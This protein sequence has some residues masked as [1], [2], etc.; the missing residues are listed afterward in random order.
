M[1]SRLF[2]I[3]FLFSLLL[4]SFP[5]YAA[6]FE[7][8][9]RDLMAN[10][11]PTRQTLCQFYGG[12][13]LSFEQVSQ[14]SLDEVD[15]LVWHCHSSQLPPE[16]LTPQAVKQ[17]KSFIKR[18]G[19][20]FLVS[21][22]Q[23]YTV[24][25]GLEP[26]M[27]DRMDINIARGRFGVHRRVE[28]PIFAGL[29]PEPENPDTFLLSDGYW[30]KVETSL[31]Q[32]TKPQNSR[33]LGSYFRRTGE[34]IYD[35][36]SLSSLNEWSLGSGKVLGYGHNIML[37]Q[38]WDNGDATN[39]HTFLRN[40][41]SYLSE[42]KT[43]TPVVAV[44]PE[45]PSRLHA[46]NHMTPPELPRQQ[47]HSLQRAL[48]GLPYIG[49]FGWLGAVNYQR[50]RRNPPVDLDYFQD[51]L[52]DETW[53]WGGNL[54]E[55]FPEDHGF[56]GYS[57]TWEKDN[58]IPRAQSYLQKEPFWP[59]WD[60]P[61]MRQVT[62]HAHQRDFL[63]HTF[64]HRRPARGFGET[65][66]FT[67]LVGRE[68]MNP[69]LYSW[70]Q[71]QDGFGVEGWFSDP[72]GE[73]FNRI[74]PYNP[75]SYFHT[76]A[77]LPGRSP[78]LSGSWMCA[79]GRVRGSFTNGFGNRWRYIQHPPLFLSYQADCRSR[80]PSRK[81]SGWSSAYGG[82]STPDWIMRQVNDFCRDRL[83]MDSA[84][85]WLGEPSGTMPAEFRPY[86]YAIS[87]NPMRV[88]LTTTLHDIGEHGY[89][90]QTVGVSKGRIP[91]RWSNKIPFPSN[92]S[93]I[94]NNYFR[95][96]RMVGEDRGVLQYDPHRTAFFHDMER[97]H[98][99]VEVSA[100]LLSCP[101]PI[102]DPL[103]GKTDG[104]VL[105]LGVVDGSSSEFKDLGGYEMTYT[106]GEGASNFP[107]KLGYEIYPAWP[108][109]VH[110]P[111]FLDAGCYSLE[112][113]T[114]PVDA[115]AI[116]HVLLDGEK[117]GY[118]F[119]T[120]GKT[121]YSVPFSIAQPGAHSLS[122]WVERAHEFPRRSKPS[123]Q[124]RIQRETPHTFDALRVRIIS[125]ISITHKRL[126]AVGHT[127]LL[128][129][130]VCF[131]SEAKVK[132]VRRYSVNSD[133]PVLRIE[134]E[135]SAPTAA[136]WQARL[137]LANYGELQP[138]PGQS[139]TW[140]L[141][142]ISKESP[143][144]GL[145]TNGGDI[146]SVKKS[147]DEVVVQFANEKEST[148]QLALLVDDGLYRA[149]DYDVLRSM[150]FATRPR[151]KVKEEQP[152]FHVNALTIPRVEVVEITNPPDGPY[153][154]AETG[155]DGQVYWLVR[156]AQVEGDTDYLSLYL[157][158]RGIAKVQPYGFIEGVV[159]PGWGCQYMLGIRDTL[160][161]R[162]CEVK[163]VKTGPF[164]FAPRIEWKKP[165]DTVWVDG[166]PWRYFDGNVVFL[167]NRPG[168]YVVH[169]ATTG[170]KAPTVSR[171]F[172]D[173]ESA[174]W[175]AETQTLELDLRAPHWWKGPLA[176]DKPYALSVLC[177][178]PPVHLEGKG[179]IIPWDKYRARPNELKKMKAQGA[180]LRL[181]PGK[182]RITF[183]NPG[184]RR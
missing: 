46:D 96:S 34:E 90:D 37:E 170:N 88:A 151:L 73:T 64:W 17:I 70:Q 109:E 132:Q 93:I 123:M 16:A 102:I 184:S 14:G 75:G 38:Y 136:D 6:G 3:S 22:A 104:I 176:G 105:S 15:V 157:Q 125:D 135:N 129:E 45:T 133:F 172:L 179:E 77:V 1:F 5:L 51:K 107:A 124:E 181:W 57:M 156:G 180:T 182:A 30:I 56:L 54:L 116:V 41:V 43:P 159:K 35:P 25:L 117:Q 26:V 72:E 110:L 18:G 119:P 128:E 9:A 127:A 24:N 86:V 114:L 162:R 111:M 178:R 139:M 92:S 115:N 39:L 69:L 78:A 154:V 137:N 62:N 101:T 80:R 152:V 153:M 142:A 11:L 60:W 63:I 143:A 173:V 163:V 7:P 138:I 49:H 126:L 31:W 8:D 150:I 166:K 146:V 76:T 89:R 165:F 55:F 122:F 161:P 42:K 118:Y 169:V 13:P 113:N 81:E 28:H 2:S 98:A 168:N 21:F 94:Q 71:S 58:P 23:S 83:Y 130:T 167:P 103:Q 134:I 53:R 147:G 85:W 145:F 10:S 61:Q 97:R 106:A 100:N 112:I 174:V 84:I 27:P 158:A 36:Q 32:K 108:Q 74:W 65:M 155:G 4:A 79:M 68:L 99:V 175:N 40:A 131:D 144:L 12:Q 160:E 29:R 66:D 120:P 44:L 50:V 121:C 171:T 59:Q 67:E 183:A 140:R 19:G 148:A 87:A 91:E 177:D 149:A 52:I 20:L 48:P 82:G 95:L 33:V 47:P 164:V 141:E